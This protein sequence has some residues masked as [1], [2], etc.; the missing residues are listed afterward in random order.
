MASAS[1]VDYSHALL[2]NLEVIG[3]MI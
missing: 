2:I 1:C 3:T